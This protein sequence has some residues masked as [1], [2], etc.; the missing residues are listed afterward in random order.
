[1]EDKFLSISDGVYRTNV[2][3]MLRLG[4]IHKFNTVEEA[5]ED[6][7]AKSWLHFPEDSGLSVFINDIK[8]IDQDL[9]IEEALN[10]YKQRL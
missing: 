1:M 9:T 10:E 6:F 7:T 2:E 3:L 4:I 5:V 8:Q